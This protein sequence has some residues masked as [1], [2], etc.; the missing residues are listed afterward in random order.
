MSP[1]RVA[2]PGGCSSRIVRGSKARFS[3]A[4]IAA[5]KNTMISLAREKRAL[6]PC[7]SGAA[8]RLDISLPH[9]ASCFPGGAWPRRPRLTRRSSTTAGHGSRAGPLSGMGR[10]GKDNAAAAAAVQP[11]R[12]VWVYHSSPPRKAAAGAVVE[13][14]E[15]PVR[16]AERLPEAKCKRRSRGGHA[17]PGSPLTRKVHAG[18]HGIR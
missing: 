12:G 14:H 18:K 8:T 3:R 6:S 4:K 9:R 2:V 5:C 17:A 16:D 7:R 15:P 13:K 11:G 10:G 1:A